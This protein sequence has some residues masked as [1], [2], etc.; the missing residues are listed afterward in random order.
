MSSSDDPSLGQLA[1]RRSP[2]RLTR[3][4]SGLLVVDVQERLV[5]AITDHEQLVWNTRRL[6]DG[7]RLFAIP[8]QGTE[9]YPAGLGPTVSPLA[10]RLGDMPAKK[11]FSACGCDTLPHAWIE[12]GIQ[13]VVVAG[14]EAHVCILQ[15][16]L[17]LLSAGF[18]VH[19]VVDAVASRR[20]VDYQT[21]LRRME[22]QGAVLTTVE[23]VLFEWC[24]TAAD[25][26]F[27]QL[28]ALVREPPPTE[29]C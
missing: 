24:E 22:A 26:Q 18:Q 9:Q 10:E 1:W 12:S 25:P 5:P 17:D 15:T 28:S 2:E 29:S 19:V 14:I 3:R 23:T 21:A 20:P 13:K 11:D 7:A 8:C 6:L 27:K 16:V 4:N